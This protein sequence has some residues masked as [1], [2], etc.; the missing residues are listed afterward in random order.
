MGFYNEFIVF[1]GLLL[2]LIF[3]SRCVYS[4]EASEAVTVFCQRELTEPE[5][6][7]LDHL[8]VCVRA[9]MFSGSLLVD[10]RGIMEDQNSLILQSIL[11]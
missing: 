10:Y 4:L 1:I 7:L 11:P 9:F 2:A 3:K 8:L 6:S 5:S